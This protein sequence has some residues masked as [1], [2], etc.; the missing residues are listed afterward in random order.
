MSHCSPA[1]GSGSPGFPFGGLGGFGGFGFAAAAAF[2]A[3]RSCGLS[4]STSSRFGAWSG[5]T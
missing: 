5:A 3:D 4:F 1:S 2:T